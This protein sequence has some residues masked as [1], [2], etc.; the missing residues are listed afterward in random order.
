MF[1]FVGGG[2]TYNNKKKKYYGEKEII[3][4]NNNNNNNIAP[5][6]WGREICQCKCE[7]LLWNGNGN[8]RYIIELAVRLVVGYKKINFET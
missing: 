3:V 4:N 6:G 5:I 2:K 8:V 7:M 1:P